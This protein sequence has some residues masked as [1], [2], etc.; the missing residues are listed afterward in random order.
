[1]AFYQ[2]NV[3]AKSV[4]EAARYLSVRNADVDVDKAKNIIVYGKPSGSSSPVVPGLSLS[5]VPDPVWAS[6]GAFPAIN[7]VTVSITGYRFTPLAAS[8]FGIGFNNIVFS[9]IRATMR[10]PT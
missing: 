6:N 10:S 4:R 1:R 7:T 9:P 8:V 2:Y 5:N 3:L